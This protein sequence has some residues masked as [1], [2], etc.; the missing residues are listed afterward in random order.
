MAVVGHELRTPVT[1]I[2]GLAE[3]LATATPA[4]VRE[5]IAPA[6]AR[7]AARVERLLDDLLLAAGIMTALP[8][9]APAPEPVL[10]AIRSAWAALGQ[11]E[12]R[13]VVHGGGTVS[14]L[15]AP[16]GLDRILGAVLDNAAKYGTGP[17]TVEVGVA[18]GEVR[19]EV[20]SR[21]PTPPPSD[22]ALAF[23]PFY[24]GEAAVTA[25]P[26]LGVGLPV[27]RAIAEQAGGRVELWAADGG[28]VVARVVLRAAG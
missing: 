8:A 21:G 1:T 5:R 2:R 9:G 6:L 17:V 28:G 18:D 10:A 4:E 20:T 26:G 27:A 11:P 19:I 13:L 24:R 15:V 14:A 3:S 12:E 23:E 16:G 25:S 7:L 22:L